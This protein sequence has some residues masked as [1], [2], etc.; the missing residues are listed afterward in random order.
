M[1]GFGEH[2]KHE[3]ET[4][5]V[6]LREISDA[7][8]ISLRY[9]EALEQN[10]FDVLPGGVFNRGF[11]RAYA[12]HI[13]IDCDATVDRYLREVEGLGLSPSEPPAPLPAPGA[14]NADPAAARSTPP[15]AFA[16]SRP[17]TGRRP[18]ISGIA[19]ADTPSRSPRPLVIAL[20]SIVGSSLVL[21]VLLLFTAP[22]KSESA[23]P[24]GQGGPLLP[25]V[26]PAGPAVPARPDAEATVEDIPADAVDADVEGSRPAPAA[27]PTPPP[28]TRGSPPAV[29]PETR[30]AATPPASR[31]KPVPPDLG[32]AAVRR[33]RRARRDDESG[34]DR[35]L[36]VSE[37]DPCQRP[38][39]RRRG[40]SEH[41][42][43][44]LPAARGRGRAGLWLYDTDRRP[45]GDLPT[46]RTRSRPT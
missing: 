9:L 42:R 11:V 23:Q 27:E 29:K 43:R 17:G 2:L 28:V 5:Q 41:Q 26:E 24:P 8:K 30:P 38:D 16:A 45:Q 1:S 35:R 13:G 21:L 19:D 22:W 15:G 32:L 10:R 14:P 20:W 25:T 3:R 18:V 34:R 33:R 46:V 40:P 39:G 4:R 44:G 12:E 31:P 6:S 36:R 37:P 7:T